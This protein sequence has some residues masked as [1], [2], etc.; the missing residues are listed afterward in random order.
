MQTNTRDELILAR[1]EWISVD[2]IG[3]MFSLSKN[4][5]YE[6]LSSSGGE[7][8]AVRLG[9]TVRVNK[10]SLLEYVQNH[11]YAKVEA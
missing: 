11:P 5:S 3:R 2:E 8:R 7:I 10:A 4:K 6:L 9:R 1:D